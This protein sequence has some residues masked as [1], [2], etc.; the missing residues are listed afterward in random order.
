[1]SETQTT[2]LSY[3]YTITDLKGQEEISRDSFLQGEV[4]TNLVASFSDFE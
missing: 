2:M 1:M 4:F 3:Q